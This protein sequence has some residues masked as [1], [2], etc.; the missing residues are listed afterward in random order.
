MKLGGLSLLDVSALGLR[1]LAA[2]S[3]RRSGSDSWLLPSSFCLLPSH[4]A[5]GGGG[6]WRRRIRLG[7]K[8]GVQ[9]LAGAGKV[10]LESQG[11]LELA[12]GFADAALP[13]EGGAQV[14]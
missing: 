3:R 11:F 2:L 4:S 8:R 12:D 7:G 6:G 9:V 13:I 14:A 10:R 1:T 5:V